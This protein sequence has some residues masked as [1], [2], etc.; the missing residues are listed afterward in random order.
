MK[1]L[2]VGGI[3]GS[4]I[5]FRGPLLRAILN[6]GHS[7]F[8]A[9]GQ[10]TPVLS[11]QL[12][13]M[14]V[15]H[16]AISMERAGV[17][18]VTD[19]MVIYELNKLFQKIR[20][21]IALNY[22][23][24]PVIY[25]S[26]VARLAGVP[27]VFSMIEGLGYA[28]TEMSWK[29]K[30]IKL[31]SKV[32]YKISLTNNAAVFFLNPDD[33]SLFREECLIGEQ[34]EDIVLNGIGVDLDHYTLAPMTKTPS[35]LLIARLL[36]DKGIR[37]YVAAARRVKSRYPHALFRLVGGTDPN[38]SCIPMEEV[39]GW[40]REGVIEYLGEVSDVRPAIAAS[41]V[42]VLP[43]YR[44][45]TPRTVLEAMSMGRPIITTDAP[46]CRETVTR[47]PGNQGVEASN[48]VVQGENGF[49]VPVRDVD[50]MVRAME[51]FIE[52]P[53]L[54][55]KMGQRSREIAEEKYDVHK[56]NAVILETMGL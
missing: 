33:K 30:I 10:T 52:D 31:A 12:R 39:R 5:N 18:P 34:S 55:E 9:S 37:E 26:L 35:F 46:G 49:L 25:G 6:R 20:P 22:T 56:V 28:F 1:I 3:A 45:G 15:E 38:P 50:S 17:N 51:Y 7:V 43:S 41:S 24:K 48:G 8:T 36:G 14:G 21:D 29:R 19:S 47:N 23:V 42:Y 32:L 27:R 16:N 44:E 40:V 13:D 11:S 2:V 54:A 4:L 53:D